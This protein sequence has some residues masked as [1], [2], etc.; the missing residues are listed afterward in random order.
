ML[1][2]VFIEF[3]NDIYELYNGI[4]L[5]I[6]RGGA[7]TLSELSFL[8][9]PFVSIPLPS[10]KDNHQFHNSEYSHKKNSLM[11]HAYEIK[12]SINGIKYY[13]IAEPPETFKK[14]LKEKYLK[15]F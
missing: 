10:A 14:I 13:Y 2:S 6:T 3:T 8:N 5:A 15:I 9:I 12:F 1:W 11:L 7:S 4:D